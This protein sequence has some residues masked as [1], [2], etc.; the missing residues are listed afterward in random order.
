M[1][2]VPFSQFTRKK[3]EKP[4]S[5]PH[6]TDLGGFL[7]LGALCLQVHHTKHTFVAASAAATA[8]F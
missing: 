6:M 1:Y 4:A 7:M 5:L 2:L 8:T 3:T